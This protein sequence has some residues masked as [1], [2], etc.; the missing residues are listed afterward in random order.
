MTAAFDIAKRTAITTAFTLDR[1][2]LIDH[3][4]QFET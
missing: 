4:T 2:E 1:D 3:A